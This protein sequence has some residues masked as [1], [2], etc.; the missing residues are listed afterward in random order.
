MFILFKQVFVTNCGTNSLCVNFSHIQRM[1]C[2]C[3][4]IFNVELQS[5][6]SPKY[7]KNYIECFIMHLFQSGEVTCSSTTTNCP[8]V[9]CEHP[10]VKQGE[11]CPSC[12][13]GCTFLRRRFRNGQKFV[14]PG[15]DAC[16]VCTC[17]VR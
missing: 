2:T 17:Q 1:F 15:G 7:L 16:H 5:F 4:S 11:C 13:G 12:G 14:P 3:N 10:E 9:P 6:T 8:A